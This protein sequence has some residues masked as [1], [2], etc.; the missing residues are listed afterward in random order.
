[1]HPWFIIHWYSLF[2]LAFSDKIGYQHLLIAFTCLLP[3]A[4]HLVENIMKA[5]KALFLLLLSYTV[6]INLDLSTHLISIT[7]QSILHFFVL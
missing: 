3:F 5:H 2:L 6:Y 7:I 4:L 1:M